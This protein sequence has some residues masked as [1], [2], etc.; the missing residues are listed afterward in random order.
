[1]NA[2]L[3]SAHLAIDSS[4]GMSRAEWV[5]LEVAIMMASVRM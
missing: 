5:A 2:P 1:M 4:P 3:L